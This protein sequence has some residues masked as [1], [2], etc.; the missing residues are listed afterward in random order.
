MSDWKPSL[1]LILAVMLLAGLVSSSVSFVFASPS[2]SI[3]L[4]ELRWNANRFPLRVLVDMNEWSTAEYAVA[5][6]EALDSWVHS[7]W[8]YTNRFGGT[9]LNAVGYTFFLSNVNYTSNYNV[10]I[11][12]NRDEMGSGFVGLTQYTTNPVTHEPIAP[13]TINVTTYRK[14]IYTLFVKNVAM[15]EFGHALGLGHASSRDTSNG[16]ELMY[17]SSSENQ[18]VYPSTL[19]VYALTR[20][21]AG[22]FNQAVELPSSIPY[23][24][25]TD[26]NVLPPSSIMM[27]LETYF[28]YLIIIV[29]LLVVIILVLALL[30]ATRKPRP[31]ETTSE[32]P[33]DTVSNMPM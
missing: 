9:S 18:I 26:G 15:H 21:Y 10:F 29:I 12:F 22:N 32:T 23:E 11:S 14:T 16:Q 31:E 13:I 20:L 6:R 27:F 5:V 25:L 1:S 33:S 17:P 7:I 30:K 3:L 19:D 28:Q 4:E 8:N 2:D 24:M